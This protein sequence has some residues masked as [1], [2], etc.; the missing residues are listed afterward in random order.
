ML[1][2]LP[3]LR[4]AAILGLETDLVTGNILGTS[5]VIR[6]AHQRVIPQQMLC[7]RRKQCMG[8][9]TQ[10]NFPQPKGT[11]GP[12]TL[13]LAASFVTVARYPNQFSFLKRAYGYAFSVGLGDV[14]C[15][16]RCC[17]E[18]CLGK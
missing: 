8:S 10:E 17:M 16:I 4:F 18:Q 1:D 3:S 7:Y 5:Q 11:V 9:G 14:M 13:Q 12:R 2:H 15:C 6:T